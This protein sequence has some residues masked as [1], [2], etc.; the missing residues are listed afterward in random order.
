ME[1]V[2]AVGLRVPP[3]TGRDGTK[4]ERLRK[5]SNTSSTVGLEARSSC[6]ITGKRRLN[7]DSIPWPILQRDIFGSDAGSRT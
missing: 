5:Y 7:V 2:T 4:T 1:I 6:I 3:I